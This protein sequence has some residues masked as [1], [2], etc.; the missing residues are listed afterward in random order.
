MQI[1]AQCQIK[2]TGLW[3]SNMRYYFNGR[4]VQPFLYLQRKKL[5]TKKAT[6]LAAFLVFIQYLIIATSQPAWPKPLLE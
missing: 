6:L 4:H 3:C 1:H 5:N 2:A